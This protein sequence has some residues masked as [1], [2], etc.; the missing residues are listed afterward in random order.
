MGF[1]FCCSVPATRV[2]KRVTRK[3]L[4]WRTGNLRINS[5]VYLI[6]R[7]RL[8]LHTSGEVWA[9]A[10]ETSPSPWYILARGLYHV[11]KS[12]TT[13]N[14]HLNPKMSSEDSL[15]TPSPSLFSLLSTWPLSTAAIV[16]SPNP[17]GPPSDFRGKVSDFEGKMEIRCTIG[18]KKNNDT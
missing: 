15:S 16:G 4:I 13:G 17:W 1:I 7:D 11:G 3:R 8:C 9:D 10:S 14:L 18:C 6:D 5:F 2:Q 12:I